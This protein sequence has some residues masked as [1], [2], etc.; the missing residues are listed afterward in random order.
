M[1]LRTKKTIKICLA[2]IGLAFWLRFIFRNSLKNSVQSANQSEAAEGFLRR[3]LS[4]LGFSGNAEAVAE[5]A[6]RKAAHIFE[7]FV[8]FLLLA[9]LFALLIK[10]INVTVICSSAL[11]FGFACIDECLQIISHR[12]A[13]VRDVLIDSVGVAIGALLYVFVRKKRNR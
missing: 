10:S 12:G 6:V 5:I 13:S 8:L 7:F 11:A 1:T 2:V 4:S 9:A 3:I